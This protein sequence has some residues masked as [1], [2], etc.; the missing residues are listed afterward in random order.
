M[1]KCDTHP[2]Q[3]GASVH[4]RNLTIWRRRIVSKSRRNLDPGFVQRLKYLK[5]GRKGN[6]G[7]SASGVAFSAS[8]LSFSAD[9]CY[10]QILQT[11]PKSKICRF[12]IFSS[13]GNEESVW[14]H[15]NSTGGASQSAWRTRSVL[16]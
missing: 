15:G 7:R 3:T 13:H 1:A 10:P 9:A 5:T 2:F 12:R 6:C 16:K 4:K 11:R 14:P 8:E